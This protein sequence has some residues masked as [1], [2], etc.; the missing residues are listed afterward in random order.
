M[1][2]EPAEDFK[3]KEDIFHQSFQKPKT[4][5]TNIVQDEGDDNWFDFQSASDSTPVIYPP[6]T[7]E[8][9]NK[10]KSVMGKLDIKP[11]E[12]AKKI[13]EDKWLGPYLN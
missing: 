5:A 9:A 1:Q 7:E 12:W 11:P 6:M 2:S 3:G 4:Y 10:I 8:K 13:P